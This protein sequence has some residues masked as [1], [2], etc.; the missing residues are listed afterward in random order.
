[1][2]KITG[3]ARGTRTRRSMH[4]FALPV[5]GTTF[6]T[7]TNEEKEQTVN[8]AQ[9]QIAAFQQP[10][11]STTLTLLDA[12]NATPP[13]I[14]QS[15]MANVLRYY[16][17]ALVIPAEFPIRVDIVDDQYLPVSPGPIV[18]AILNDPILAPSS[19]INDVFDCD[20]YVMYLRTKLALY[21]QQNHAPAPFALGIIL[22]RV[23]AFNFCIDAQK[24][25]FLID[26]QSSTKP[27]TGDPQQFGS[28]LGLSA[29]N[30][31]RLIYI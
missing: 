8:H 5:E 26:T 9:D 17:Q 12:I 7:A 29:A 4:S 23:H 6:L 10:M 2:R 18:T 22:T 1:M 19:Y 21:A 3:S 31:V 13:L 16:F 24:Q 25:P 28:F 15:T 30:S 11:T 20:D 14:D 27:V